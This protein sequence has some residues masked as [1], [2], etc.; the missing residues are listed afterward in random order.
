MLLIYQ[1]F[2][3]FIYRYDLALVVTD[4]T[5][6]AEFVVRGNKAEELIGMSLMRIIARNCPYKINCY[7][8]AQ[9]IKYPPPEFQAILSN[10]YK[11]VVAVKEQSFYRARPSF[12]ITAVQAAAVG[13]NP[14]S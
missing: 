6:E 9:G 7:I 2:L 11:F 12:D 13:L 8:A 4:G 14:S 10:R 3:R 5:D 1:Q